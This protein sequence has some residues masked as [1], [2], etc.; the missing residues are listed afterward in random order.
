MEKILTLDDVF[1]S[2]TYVKG[3]RNYQSPKEYLGKFIDTVQNI[4]PDINIQV[5][6][7]IQNAEEDRSINTAYSRIMIEA[8]N[9]RLNSN[10]IFPTFGILLGLDPQIP[11][12]KMYEG[13]TVSACTN[14]CVFNANNLF[15]G[16]VFDGLNEGYAHLDSWKENYKDTFGKNLDIFNRLEQVQITPNELEQ[17]LGALLKFGIENKYLGTNPIIHAAKELYNPS[18]MYHIDDNEGTTDWN[19]YNAVT[20]YLSTKTD[21]LDKA[22]K[23]LLLS[24]FFVN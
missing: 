10:G 20:S 19:I 11:V 13:M 18:S 22:S 7:K 6:G 23:T 21:I 1:E 12:Y 2:K 5:S 14:L 16:N 9:K 24:K 15:T 4:A 8:S 3:N 17:R